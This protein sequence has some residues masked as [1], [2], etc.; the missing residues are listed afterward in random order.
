MRAV[1]F[2]G[3]GKVGLEDIPVP[4]PRSAEALVKIKY[5]GI[6]GS[7]LHIFRQ[8]MFVAKLGETMGHE[9]S[10]AVVSAPPSSGL[11]PGD[12][13]VGDPRVPC[14][15]CAACIAGDTHRCSSLGFIGEVSPGAFAGYL[16]IAPEKLVTLKGGTDP[17]Q[18]ALAEP[19]AVA[20]HACRRIITAAG[21]GNVLVLGAG[22]IGLLMAY[23]F[24]N[25]YAVKRVGV[26]EIDPFRLGK[27][28]EAGADER[29]ADIESLSGQYSCLVDAVGV[30]TVLNKAIGAAA[31]GGC[32]FISAIYERTPQTDINTLVSKEMTLVGNNAY[33]FDDL[34]EAAALI[35]S[36]KYDFRWLVTSIMSAEEAARGF[37]LLTGKEKRDLKILL[38]FEGE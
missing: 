28:K 29:S 17:A 12:L 37:E 13:V 24:K 25:V 10:G 26:F 5:G 14:G 4:V 23:L 36:G 7:D 33:S 19:L 22:P 18:A 15:T 31:P 2:Y 3:P 27:A 32:V 30:E 20:V 35:G 16:A 11:S 1:K 21:S 38:R 34:K 9:F 6:C 8:G